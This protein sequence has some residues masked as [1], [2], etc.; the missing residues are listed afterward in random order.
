MLHNASNSNRRMTAPIEVNQHFFSKP[1]NGFTWSPLKSRSSRWCSHTMA[2]IAGSQE[3]SITIR[4]L[5]VYLSAFFLSVPIDLA[6]LGLQNYCSNFHFK[7]ISLPILVCV[8]VCW[9]G[10]ICRNIF[11]VFNS[12]YF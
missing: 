11:Y 3:L 4:P 10:G 12:C 8:C 7:R 9:G 1:I 6:A 5:P 2:G